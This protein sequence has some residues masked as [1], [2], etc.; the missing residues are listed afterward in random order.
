[1]YT[2]PPSVFEPIYEP[3]P[4]ESAPVAVVPGSV[5]TIDI[6]ATD[7]VGVERV[8]IY[9][10]ETLVATFQSGPYRVTWSVPMLAETHWI[11]AIAYDQS[12][13]SSVAVLM[14]F[15]E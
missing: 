6:R 3:E 11:R 1:V 13:K 9:V 12:G 15:P 10:D 4:V 8:E 14:A 7:D 2:P 5:V